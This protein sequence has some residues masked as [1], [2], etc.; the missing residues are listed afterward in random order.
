MAA[1]VAV[2][3]LPA[4]PATASVRPGA[5]A[6]ASQFAYATSIVHVD[7][8]DYMYLTGAHRTM[9]PDHTRT[10]AFAKRARCLTMKTK[11]LK[12]IACA[13]FVF[14]RRV[15]EDAFEFDPLL[16][17][18]RLHFHNGRGRTDMTWAARGTPEPDA[19]PY[20]DPNYGGGVYAD[21]WQGA[22]AHGKI[23]G[24]RYPARRFGFALLSE[25]AS[26]DGYSGRDMTI[27][28]VAGGALKVE[29]LYRIAR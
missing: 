19:G 6:A 15:S 17:S 26:F 4:W 29:A 7:G 23:I 9:S 25:G 27:T 3:L 14:P 20:V 24:E 13:A 28:P 12:L 8:H 10:T 11:R 2:G 21:I 5:D 18:A 16:D 22:V 1:V